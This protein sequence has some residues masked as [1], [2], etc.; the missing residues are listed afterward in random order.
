MELSI[1][2]GTLKALSDPTDNLGLI[3]I[4]KMVSYIKKSLVD[5]CYRNIGGD[6]QN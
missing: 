5:F 3:K 4:E 2:N 6:C 1:H